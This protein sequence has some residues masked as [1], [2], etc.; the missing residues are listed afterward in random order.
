MTRL[1]NY[2][3]VPMLDIKEMEV[4]TKLKRSMNTTMWIGLGLF[5]VSMLFLNLAEINVYLYFAIMLGLISILFLTG[6]FDMLLMDIMH[7]YI[8][9]NYRRKRK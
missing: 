5:F 8:T 6:Y 4:S 7:K 2:E 9:E 1:N 3:D